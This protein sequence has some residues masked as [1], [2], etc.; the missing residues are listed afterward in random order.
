MQVRIG[1]RDAVRGEHPVDGRRRRARL[2]LGV[3]IRQPRLCLTLRGHRDRID[4]RGARAGY[5]LGLRFGVGLRTSSRREPPVR[6]RSAEGFQHD[7]PFR[8]AV[9]IAAQQITAIRGA[10]LPRELHLD[11]EEETLGHGG[12]VSFLRPRRAKR[13]VS[14]MSEASATKGLRERL[15]SSTEDRLGKALTDLFE[16]PVLHGA[17]G[18]AAD[19]R[20]KATQAQELAMGALNLPSAADVERLTRRLR[21]VSQRLE[22]IEDGVHRLGRTFPGQSIDSRLG[23]IEEQLKGLSKTLG[24]LREG[25]G[26]KLARNAAGQ[27]SKGAAGQPSESAASKSSQ[28][29]AGKAPKSAAGKAPKSA[30]GKAPKS[31]AGKTS[32]SVAD[33]APKSTAGKAPKSAVGKTPKSTAAKASKSTAAKASKSTAAK[34]PKP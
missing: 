19:A 3:H 32:Q 18:R 14:G 17:L 2:A 15:T 9:G 6:A 31:A 24:E 13:G 11:K 1:G 7:D 8:L 29:V 12:T 21:S 16:S 20:E 23:A 22:G 33:K 30:A 4:H 10:E 28:G 34:R 25:S 26:A 5:G 27:P